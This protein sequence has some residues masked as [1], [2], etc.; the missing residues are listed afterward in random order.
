M[1]NLTIF[2][3]EVEKGMDCVSKILLQTNP[4]LDLGESLEKCHFKE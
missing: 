1:P 2:S 4:F 3:I